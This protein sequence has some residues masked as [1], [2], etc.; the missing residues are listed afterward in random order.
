[1]PKITHAFAI[2]APAEKVYRAV[3]EEDGISSWFTK[4]TIAKP[5][6][7]FTDEFF[8]GPKD[9][10]VKGR[11]HNEM[12]VT[13]LVPNKAI[14]WDC[15][16]GDESWIGTKLSF[17]LTSGDGKTDVLFTHSDWAEQ[18]LF[19]AHCN[20]NW[21]MFMTSLKQYCETGTGTPY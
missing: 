8:F 16:G 21:G 2:K 18:S 14:R 5:E 15:T 13:E 10:S 4:N 9:P 12:L 19:F 11:Y 6:V 7:G 20:Y 1:M 17:E 3:T